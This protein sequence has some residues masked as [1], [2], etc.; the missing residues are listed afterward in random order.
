[1]EIEI[2]NNNATKVFFEDQYKEYFI[3]K[4]N[5]SNLSKVINIITKKYIRDNGV[6]KKINNVSSIVLVCCILTKMMLD[7]KTEYIPRVNS[8]RQNDIN[9]YFWL[10]FKLSPF[11]LNNNVSAI[12]CVTITAKLMQSNKGTL[13][14][15][16]YDKISS[17]KKETNAP[18]IK[19]CH[20]CCFLMIFTWFS[21]MF[22]LDISLVNK[23]FV[24]LVA[25]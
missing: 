1:M 2:I 14:S 16:P 15:I 24:I 21:L 19:W 8:V 20:I 4:R 18:Q 22:L 25:S 6:N 3:L 13:Q 17:R 12:T 9:K 7:I 23:T 5:S 10:P 11:N